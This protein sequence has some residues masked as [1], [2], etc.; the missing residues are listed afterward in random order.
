MRFTFPTLAFVILYFACPIVCVAYYYKM[1]KIYKKLKAK[2]DEM[3]NSM[4]ENKM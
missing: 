3:Q 4:N 2:T 1:E